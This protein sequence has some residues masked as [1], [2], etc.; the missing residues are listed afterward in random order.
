MTTINPRRGEGAAAKFL[1]D[2]VLYAGDACLIWP[3][4]RMPTGYGSL[5]YLGKL[6]YAHRLM[7][8][9]VHGPDGPAM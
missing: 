3:F 7:C 8:E 1:H 6:H 5:G 4:S 9:L 2:N